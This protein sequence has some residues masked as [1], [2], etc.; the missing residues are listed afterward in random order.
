MNF[1]ESELIVLEL[2]W[3]G[4]CLDENGE[5]MASK[6]SDI[7]TE[8]YGWSKSSN[9]TFISRLLEKGAITRRYPKY[10]LKPIVSREEVGARQTE[11][12]VNSVF[13]GSFIKLF[14]AFMTQKKVS[15]EELKE[16]K[17][18]IEEFDDEDK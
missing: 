9:Y 14:S 13:N 12:V 7:L 18:I 8:K 1:S 11:E 15:K 2:L 4:E 3:E 17:K 6:L 16:M 10:T 5:I